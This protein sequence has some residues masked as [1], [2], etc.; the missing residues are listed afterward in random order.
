MDCVRA[1][2]YCTGLSYTFGRQ[3][4]NETKLWDNPWPGK[5]V[6]VPELRSTHQAAVV[7]GTMTSKVSGTEEQKEAV[8]IYTVSR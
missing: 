8:Q 7:G 5:A 1:A 4:R 6:L 3:E 2:G